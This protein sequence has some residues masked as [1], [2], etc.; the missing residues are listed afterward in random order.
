M[1]LSPL[2]LSLRETNSLRIFDNVSKGRVDNLVLAFFSRWELYLLRLKKLVVHL[3]FID[4]YIKYDFLGPIF[5]VL[6]R[7]GVA[8]ILFSPMY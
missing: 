5:P 7:R 4:D 6:A 2:H 1:Y 3:L 8:A